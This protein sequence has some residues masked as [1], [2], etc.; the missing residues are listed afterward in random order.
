M[1]L[2]LFPVTTVGS[3]PRSPELL[4]ALRERRRGEI[5]E[6]RFLETARAGVREAL[7]AQL[8]AGVDLVTDGEQ[9]RDNF[10]SFVA[11]KLD[12][13]RLMTLAEM[14]DVVEDKEGFSRL[15]ETL[16]VPAFSISNPTCVGRIRLRAPLAEDDLGY[17]RTLTDR[18]VKVT[19]PGPY[20][21]T[22]AMWVPEATRDAYP[23]KESLG[24]DVVAILRDEI[25]RLARAG[26]DFIQLDEPV[27]T[28]LVFTQ[29]RTRTFMCAA[30]AARRDPAEELTFA[31]DLLS[32]VVATAGNVRTG[33]HVCRGNWSRDESTLLAGSYAPL[34]AWFER[35]PIRQ[36]VLEYATPRAGDYV[37][38]AGKEIGL[39]VVNPR[40]DEIEEPAAICHRVERL[41]SHMDAGRIFLN[42]D[43]GFGTF[44]S[45]PMNAA[46]V[47]ERKLAAIAAAAKTL[48]EKHGG[49][50]R[51]N[52]SF[53]GGT[54]RW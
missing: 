48:R 52:T 29:G 18:P 12:G 40:S 11:G 14:L 34:A 5:P 13:V 24:A 3:W 1:R 30:L 33:L 26:A 53:G 6:A 43:C 31:M 10:Y 21:L 37:P 4:R 8:A 36:L 27:L 2:P 15:L 54:A 50:P 16:D 28:E 7:R 41:L 44:A 39:G 49:R 42:P 9:T 17:L 25:A 35:A 22:R 38:V 46:P 51:A 45:R 47:A 32:Q 23:D 19:L 20:L